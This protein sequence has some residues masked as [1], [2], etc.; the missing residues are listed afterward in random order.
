MSTD[1]TLE[2]PADVPHPAARHQDPALQHHGQPRQ[3]QPPPLH[4]DPGGERGVL[5]LEHRHDPPGVLRGLR[6]PGLP[7]ERPLE[8]A[9]RKE[10]GESWLQT[11]RL[12]WRV[13]G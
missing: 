6:P 7:G 9:E 8:S 1:S 12:V 2:L 10:A 4:G 13:S 5:P 3:D 11:S